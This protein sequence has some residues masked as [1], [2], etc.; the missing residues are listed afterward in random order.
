M[1]TSKRTPCAIRLST[2][3]PVRAVGAQQVDARTEGHDLDRDPVRPIEFQQIVGDADDQALLLGVVVG[4]L[5]RQMMLGERACRQQ[6]ALGGGRRSGRERRRHDSSRRQG[7][8]TEA[9]QQ[10]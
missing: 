6:R 2:N 1:Q 4:K 8:P 10:Q 3:V 9:G 5:Q 7:R